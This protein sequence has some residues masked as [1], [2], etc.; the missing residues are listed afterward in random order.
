[1]LLE[2][3]G[4]DPLGPWL[5]GY[6]CLCVSCSE[7]LSTSAK[8]KR[9]EKHQKVEWVRETSREIWPCHT[10]IRDGVTPESWLNQV[11]ARQFSPQTRIDAWIMLFFCFVLSF[12]MNNSPTHWLALSVCHFLRLLPFFNSALLLGLV[13]WC[14]RAAGSE[15]C[16]V[17]TWHS[18]V[19]HT[20]K[21]ATPLHHYPVL[22]GTFSAERYSQ[23]IRIEISV[24][25]YD[26]LP[27]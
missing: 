5:T 22:T 3:F 15:L 25:A 6:R 13:S 27:G 1:M 26:D 9:F 14:S 24:V 4:P 10:S 11:E 21:S 19:A 16:T 18:S 7:G 23:E 20:F 17:V 2:N 8:S 12:Y